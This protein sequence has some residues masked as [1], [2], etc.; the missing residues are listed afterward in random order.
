MPVFSHQILSEI[1]LILGKIKGDIIVK[2]HMSSFE[3]S[4]IIVRF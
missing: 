3:V 1:F 2:V 4:D